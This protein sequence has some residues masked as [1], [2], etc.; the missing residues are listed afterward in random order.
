M[1]KEQFTK[2]LKQLGFRLEEIPDYGYV[3]IFEG[4]KV[5]YKPDEDDETFFQMMLPCIYET[6]DSNRSII[7]EICNEVN[8]KIK[9]VK[10]GIIND[11]VWVMYEAK[12]YEGCNIEETLRHSLYMLQATA[13]SFERLT[14][15]KEL[16]LN[17][18]E[19]ED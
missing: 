13:F 16:P 11:N 19:N 10:V 15:G 6:D 14:T 12:Y 5:I 2:T 8:I 18:Y 4:Q 7:L 17:S 3:F 9:F 1:V